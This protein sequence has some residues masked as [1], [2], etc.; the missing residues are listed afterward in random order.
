ML[1]SK[2][3][4]LKIQVKYNIITSSYNTF[5]EKVDAKEVVQYFLDPISS[6]IHALETDVVPSEFFTIEEVNGTKYTGEK[7][8]IVSEA[9]LDDDYFVSY[10][11]PLI[12][13]DYPLETTFTV[14]RDIEELGFP[15]KKAIPVLA[16][17]PTRLE[18]DINYYRLRKRIPYRYHLPYYYKQDFKEIQYKIVNAY[19]GKESSYTKEKETYDYIINGVFPA[20]RPGFYN[21][22]MQYVL[23]GEVNG[24]ST[25]LKFK[26]PF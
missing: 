21:V 24:S 25:V 18:E 19:V 23:P 9:I 11:N 5:K 7:P 1:K 16:W 3:T 22:N 8:L 10:I 15:P 13:K 20:I 2:T 26:N 14:D 4:C 17:Y 12:Y 6:N